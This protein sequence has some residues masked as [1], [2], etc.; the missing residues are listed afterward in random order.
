MFDLVLGSLGVAIGK[1]EVYESAA[2][3]RWGILV[4]S[5]WTCPPEIGSLETL[6]VRGFKLERR[7]S[8][9]EV[10]DSVISGDEGTIG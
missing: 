5:W 10:D 6:L 8:C 1:S 9:G 7:S 2:S 4:I 3:E